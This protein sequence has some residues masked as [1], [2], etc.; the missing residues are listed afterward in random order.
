MHT[1]SCFRFEIRNEIRSET[2]EIRSE[3]CVHVH[4]ADVF[5]K[6]PVRGVAF[7]GP[8][9]CDGCVLVV[10]LIFMIGDA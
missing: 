9:P 3:T 6:Q 4:G 8:K 10:I 1:I 5:N 2:H 7:H